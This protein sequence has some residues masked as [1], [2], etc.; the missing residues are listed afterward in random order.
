MTIIL[1]G[2][3]VTMS[4]TTKLSYEQIAAIVEIEQPKIA[5]T[6]IERSGQLEPGETLALEDNMIVTA[7]QRE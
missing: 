7:V 6:K 4:T 1:N 2:H 3:A 5:W